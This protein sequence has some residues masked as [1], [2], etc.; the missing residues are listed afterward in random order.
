MRV[1]GHTERPSVCS[2]S[3]SQLSPSSG[4]CQPDT[5]HVSEETPRRPP[6]PAIRVFPAE[7]PDILEQ[8]QA[9]HH[10]WSK[11]LMH[12]SNKH[13]EMAIVFCHQV[14]SVCYTTTATATT[15]VTPLFLTFIRIQ[16]YTGETQSTKVYCPTLHGGALISA[17]I[18]LPP[19]SV[20]CPWAVLP[21]F[22]G[23]IMTTTKL[24]RNMCARGK[25]ISTL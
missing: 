6:P 20:P 25:R 10:V 19:K 18:C 4:S 23:G 8:R 13:I 2:R 7:A 3:E 17:R 15:T 21:F 1:S 9:T 11:S 12:R 24:L 16:R 5:T 14:Y 22:Q